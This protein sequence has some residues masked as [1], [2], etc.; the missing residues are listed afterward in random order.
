MTP[1]V[2]LL[3]TFLLGL[4]ST[5]SALALG[6]CDG[7]PQGDDHG[8]HDGGDDHGEVLEHDVYEAGGITK[9]TAAGHFMVSLVSDPEPPSKGLNTWTLTVMSHE[10][11]GMVEGATVTIEPWMP[12][13]DHGSD[14]EATVEAV[15]QGDYMSQTVELQMLGTWDTTVTVTSGEMTDEVHFVFMVE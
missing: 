2:T 9:A 10:D 14:S 8:H 5:T 13:H 15:G 6:G 4:L 3:R 12:E 1:P 11:M 7:E